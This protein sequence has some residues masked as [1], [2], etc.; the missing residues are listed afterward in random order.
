MM[1]PLCLF[2]CLATLSQARSIAPSVADPNQ[3]PVS[4]TR[5]DDGAVNFGSGM[6]L[7]GFTPGIGPQYGSLG[8]PIGYGGQPAYGGPTGYGGQPSYGGQQP[9]YGQP[10]THEKSESGYTSQPGYGSPSYG[11]KGGY[12][13]GY[14]PGFMSGPVYGG[15]HHHGGFGPF[16][17]HHHHGGSGGYFGGP[18]GG[19][20][21]R[22]GGKYGGHF[23]GFGTKY[24]GGF[25]G[26][27][28]RFGPY[29]VFEDMFDDQNA[30]DYPFGADLE[31]EEDD[32]LTSTSA[33]LEKYLQKQWQLGKR[34][35][36]VQ[37][38]FG[39]V[40]LE[41]EYLNQ[42]H[43][44]RHPLAMTAFGPKYG[45]A[46]P[47]APMFDYGFGPTGP[48]GG[49]GGPGY[50]YGGPGYGP[51]YGP[52]APPAPG[53]GPSQGSGYGQP[54]Q[55]QQQHPDQ[56]QQTPPAPAQQSAQTQ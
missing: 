18:Y 39:N 35:L 28:G 25:G 32:H 11:G 42:Y 8:G 52:G 40:P 53:Y 10:H 47:P 12:G 48:I 13:G 36:Q 29:G 37:V 3:V 51:G 17:G 23:G 43:G 50:G 26:Y 5:F 9:V 46:G 56:G 27:G 6:P 44:V 4:D 20:G 30:D 31:E 24:G 14:G 33:R 7:P 55:Q 41:W 54:A 22:F 16:G 19:F 38:D 1:V 34:K 15:H 45:L 2:L 21:R 49:F